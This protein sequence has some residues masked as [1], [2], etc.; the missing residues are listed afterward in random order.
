MLTSFLGG[1]HVIS[2]VGG[3]K[4]LVKL[5]EQKKK[6]TYPKWRSLHSPTYSGGILVR[7]PDSNQNFQNLVG[8]FLAVI[9]PRQNYSG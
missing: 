3:N 7:I 1:Q 4:T 9:V 5:R 2:L 8:T 6:I